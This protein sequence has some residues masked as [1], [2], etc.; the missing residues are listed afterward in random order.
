MLYVHPCLQFSKKKQVECLLKKSAS[1]TLKHNEQLRLS[2][3]TYTH[4][5]F[6]CKIHLIYA[7]DDVV[8]IWV[9]HFNALSVVLRDGSQK[10]MKII[11][12]PFAFIITPKDAFYPFISKEGTILLQKFLCAFREH[13]QREK[14]EEIYGFVIK[15]MQANLSYAYYNSWEKYSA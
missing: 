10:G 8:K 1:P 3:S 13:P 12:L 11:L 5:I 9:T 14:E 7:F 6:H 15:I 2:L 4:E